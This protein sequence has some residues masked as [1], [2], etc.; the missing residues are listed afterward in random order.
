MHKQRLRN[1]GLLTGTIVAALFGAFIPWVRGRAFPLWPWVVSGGL[2]I[3]A[4]LA[5]T[6]LNLVYQVLMRVGLILNWASTHIFLGLIFYGMVT[7]IG[8]LR[9]WFGRDPMARQWDAA[10]E[11]YR[12]DSEKTSPQ[13]LERPF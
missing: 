13:K 2:W 5:P 8:V 12:V 4:I 9:R 3:G 1:F 11:S 6:R 7:P 10:W